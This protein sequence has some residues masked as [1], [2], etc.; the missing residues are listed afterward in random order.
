MPT[1]LE[2][3]LRKKRANGVTGAEQH[4]LVGQRNIDTILIGVALA[5]KADLCTLDPQASPT[6]FG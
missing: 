2:K 3:E 5:L 6:A 4:G 1:V